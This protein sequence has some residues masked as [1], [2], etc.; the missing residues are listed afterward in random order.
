[1]STSGNY[2]KY[3]GLG[4]GGGG[5]GGGTY[6]G[7]S[8]TTVTV[9]GLPSGSAIAG[10]TFT[11]ILQSML[12]PFLAPSFS[13]FA[14]SG[15]ATSLEVGYPTASGSQ[16]FTFSFANAGNVAANTLSIID[17]TTSTT[18]A[19][20][21]PVTSPESAN[22]GGPFTLTAPGSHSWKGQA[23]DTQSTVFSSGNFTVSWFFK[24]FYGTNTN[25][26]LAASDIL[27]LTGNLAS[28]FAQTRSF[29]A[30][31]YKYYCW[32][33]TFGS[34]TAST[35]FKDT[36][37]GLPVAMATSTDNAAYSNVQNGWYYALV[38]VTNTAPTP[39]TTNYRVYRTQN[40]LGGTITIQVS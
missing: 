4:G 20:G 26:T 19:S 21:L 8:P 18:L 29:A 2:A 15:Q 1:M 13:S 28:G 40:V 3:T 35:G 17:V 9:G 31:G 39:V 16:S 36:S 38:S 25:P 27:A 34:P 32:P 7:S 22:I 10:E 37:N 12:V 30:G 24:D 5:G 6:T 33:D 23:T 14:I 11:Q